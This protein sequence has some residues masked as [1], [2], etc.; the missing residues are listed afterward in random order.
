M[1]SLSAGK[2]KETDCPLEPPEG[3]AALE[4]PGFSSS[5]ILVGILTHRTVR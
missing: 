3:K 2:G 4:T 5:E 1:G